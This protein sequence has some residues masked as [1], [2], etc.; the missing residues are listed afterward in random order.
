MG[1]A[2]KLNIIKTKET[3]LFNSS[4]TSYIIKGSILDLT[5]L[6]SN[7]EI[8]Y[9]KPYNLEFQE[10]SSKDPQKLQEIVR[11]IYTYLKKNDPDGLLENTEHDFKK[12]FK[13]TDAAIQENSFVE[14]S[15]SN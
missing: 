5:K 12:F 15:W 14:Y 6:L 10:K 2:S 9:I 8:D 7:D 4:F 11:K 1:M 3:K 13:I